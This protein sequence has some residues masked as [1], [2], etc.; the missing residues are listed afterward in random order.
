MLVVTIVVLPSA[1]VC[2]STTG[3]SDML[4][5]GVVAAVVLELASDAAEELKLDDGLDVV[6]EFATLVTALLEDPPKVARVSVIDM[7]V[8][9]EL[10]DTGGTEPMELET[11]IELEIETLTDAP[12]DDDPNVASVSVIDTGVDDELLAGSVTAL[13]VVEIEIPPSDGLL[14]RISSDEAE[15]GSS[16]YPHSL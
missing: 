8:E 14:V 5:P 10:L 3:N 13:K 12:L 16:V 11:V 9:V 4:K 2:V 7:G 1:K 15:E 6:M